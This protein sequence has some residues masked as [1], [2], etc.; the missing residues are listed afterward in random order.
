MARH[1]N[2]AQEAAKKLREHR[3]EQVVAFEASQRARRLALETAPL[4]PCPFCG[5][6]AIMTEHHIPIPQ[7]YMLKHYAVCTNMDCACSL[8]FLNSKAEAVRHWNRRLIRLVAV[9]Q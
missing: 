5:S 4:L 6:D 1:I 7:G 3:R 8:R 2:A 9:P